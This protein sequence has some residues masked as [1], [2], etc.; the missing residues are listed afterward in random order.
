MNREW[1]TSTRVVVVIVSIIL[2]A[3]LL[4][5]FQPL[6]KSLVVAGLLAYGLNL[7]VIPVAAHTRL[8]RK[9]AV[10]LVYFFLVILLIA[11]PG[12]LIPIAVNQAETVSAE[13]ALVENNIREF[14][15]DPVSIFG[16]EI[17]LNDIVANFFN[18]D[19][20]GLIADPESALTVLETTSI[21]LVRLLV[22]FVT[23]YYLLM[24]YKGL[25]SWLVNISTQSA[26]DDIR[27]LMREIDQIW[28]AYIRGTL[29]LMLIMGIVFIII[30]LAIGLPGAVGIGVVTGL[31]SMVPEIG[32]FAAGVLAVLVALFEGSNHLPIPNFWF[33]LIVAGTYFVMMQFKSIWLRP[34]VMGRFMHMNTGLVFLAIIAA[35]VLE[36]ILGALLVLPILAS[37]GLLG[38]YIRAR[39]LNLDPWS[40]ESAIIPPKPEPET[41]VETAVSP[42]KEAIGD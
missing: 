29:A 40:A 5:A 30:G 1:S 11:T 24:D 9:A 12:T 22:I 31:L 16:R 8:S 36:G 3:A 20:G 26:R 28:R 34:H 17:L 6:I 18:P 13:L 37:V 39:M 21:S 33:A 38:R 7:I 25:L 15:L 35:V 4:Y 42:T 2:L 32:P 27:R 14:L 10:N 23:T 19:G 41:V